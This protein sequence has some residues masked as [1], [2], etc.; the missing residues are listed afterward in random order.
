MKGNYKVSIPF[1]NEELDKAITKEL[2]EAINESSKKMLPHIQDS[3]I[4]ELDRIAKFQSIHF[5]IV[6]I[7]SIII[8]IPLL[9]IFEN[10]IYDVGKIHELLDFIFSTALF[11]LV[12]FLLLG[13]LER[14]LEPRFLGKS[15]QD[16]NKRSSKIEDLKNKFPEI[17]D[18]RVFIY[19]MEHHSN[20]ALQNRR[21]DYYNYL[22]SHDRLLFIGLE[23][24]RCSVKMMVSKSLLNFLP[25]AIISFLAITLPLALFSESVDQLPAL[26]AYITCVFVVTTLISYSLFL[27]YSI[28]E[29][30][31][32]DI[33][34]DMRGNAHNNNE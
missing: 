3:I 2:D 9:Y 17:V 24:A 8:V 26:I 29:N 28:E 32:E 27:K 14:Y 4:N 34:T 20:I 21:L 19:F 12:W 30:I 6:F 1:T 31:L 16:L 13:P 18:N 15:I 23:K 7:S 33:Y 25:P 5:A 10:W 22:N 11:F